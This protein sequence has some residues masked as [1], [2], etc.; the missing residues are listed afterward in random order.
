[1]SGG[2]IAMPN[3]WHAL[4]EPQARRFRGRAGWSSHALRRRSKRIGSSGGGQKISS[5]SALVRSLVAGALRQG[6]RWNAAD[7]S[8]VRKASLNSA[9][10]LSRRPAASKAG[11]H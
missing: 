9:E 10:R 5:V 6:K 1:M 4:V 3:R 2:V 11:H 8:R 7:K